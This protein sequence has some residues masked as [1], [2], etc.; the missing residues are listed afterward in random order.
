MRFVHVLLDNKLVSRLDIIWITSQKD[1]FSLALILR[2][3]DKSSWVLLISGF[4]NEI[5]II[6][7]KAI[8]CWE[9]LIIVRQ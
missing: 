9:K 1:A 6:M 3:C 2:L 5:F 4:L 8:G 7:R